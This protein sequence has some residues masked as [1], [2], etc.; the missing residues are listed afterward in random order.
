MALADAIEYQFDKKRN[1][2]QLNVNLLT[3]IFRKKNTLKSKT[4]T[5]FLEKFETTVEGGTAVD[6]TTVNRPTP[7]ALRNNWRRR[8]S[9]LRG[10]NISRASFRDDARTLGMTVNQL[11]EYVVANTMSAKKR[12]QMRMTLEMIIA[13]N[14]ENPNVGQAGASPKTVNL[15]VANHL[16]CTP[17]TSG[18]STTAP[19]TIENWFLLM[20]MLDNNAVT[21]A[22]GRGK[23]EDSIAGLNRIAI[24][25]NKGL[26]SFV[27]QVYKD[28]GN[29]DLFGT[30]LMIPGYGHLKT[31]QDTAI[32]TIPDELFPNPR[33]TTKAASNAAYQALGWSFPAAADFDNV[34]MDGFVPGQA[35]SGSV[36]SKY[37]SGGGLHRAIIMTVDAFELEVPTQY[38]VENSPYRDFTHSMEEKFFCEWG[39]ESKRLFDN[40]V[41]EVY[42]TGLGQTVK[43]L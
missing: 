22:M 36:P 34:L 20:A 37:V 8:E 23:K 40:L 15:P 42:F 29:R 5:D 12:S 14:V 9:I 39:L 24:F 38:Q 43:E 21:D 10:D 4:F 41:Y 35:A 32:I 16:L 6:L 30:P 19:L 2:L 3:H 28:L 26:A 18:G 27:A 1:D 33:P 7:T 11:A 17:T 13:A 31:I 25:S